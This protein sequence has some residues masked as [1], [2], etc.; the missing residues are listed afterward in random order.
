MPQEW[1]CYVPV[2]G[3]VGALDPS[4]TMVT[5]LNMALVGVVEAIHSR[6]GPSYAYWLDKLAFWLAR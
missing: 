1:D 5:T 3:L 4:T 2:P 6:F